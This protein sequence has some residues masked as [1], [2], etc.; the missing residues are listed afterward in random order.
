[1]DGA[2]V[3]PPSE[4]E[5]GGGRF[6]VAIPEAADTGGAGGT[7]TAAPVLAF[8][9]AN[10]ARILSCKANALALLSIGPEGAGVL[11]SGGAAAAALDASVA[12][13]HRRF[14]RL[15]LS[16]LLLAGGSF[17]DMVKRAII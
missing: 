5:D 1:M 15:C 4:P 3:A 16:P 13:P 12:S 9:A 11:G 2:V 7:E 10:R 14:R 17:D 8:K 6:S